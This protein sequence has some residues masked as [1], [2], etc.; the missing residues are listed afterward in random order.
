MKHAIA[1]ALILTS[2]PALAADTQSPATDVQGPYDQISA[3]IGA[4]SIVPGTGMQ[5][6]ERNGELVLISQNTRFLIRGPFE[7][8]DNWNETEIHSVDDMNYWAQRLKK[9]RIPVET[10]FSLTLGT[11]PKE[12]YAFIDP[13]CPNCKDLINKVVNDDE[14]MREFSMRL[15]VVPLLGEESSDWARRLA[16]TAHD[17][18]DL[19]MQSLIANDLA[20]LEGPGCDL[21]GL[22][23]NM[24]A[25]QMLGVNGVPFV[26]GEDDRVHRG[27]PRSLHQL[28]AREH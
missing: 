27:V 19:A 13:K 25:V 23:A 17:D 14:F 21:S 15:F 26:I 28:R 7:I 18:S 12:L 3:S 1:L 9:S 20:S 4:N 10:M 24:I 5:L 8:L 2:S 22:K 16:C 11:G 6:I